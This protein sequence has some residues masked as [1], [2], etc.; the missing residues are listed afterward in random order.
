MESSFHTTI[1]RLIL[2]DAD[3]RATLYARCNSQLSWERAPMYGDHPGKRPVSM[4]RTC[5]TDPPTCQA[6]F[7]SLSDL[8]LSAG[9][10]QEGRDLIAAGRLAA[11]LLLMCRHG[12]WPRQRN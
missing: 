9:A 4:A 2:K 6:W 3:T 1:L 5:L 7:R 12:R 11:S 10:A 8:L